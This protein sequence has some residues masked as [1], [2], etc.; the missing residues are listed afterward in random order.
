MAAVARVL[1]S[2]IRTPKLSVRQRN[3]RMVAGMAVPGLAVE[4]YHQP[5]AA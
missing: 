4:G 5:R 2:K 1:G 3:W